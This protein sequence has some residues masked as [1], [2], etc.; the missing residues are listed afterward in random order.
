MIVILCLVNSIA[1]LYHT[2]QRSRSA[3][4][5]LLVAGLVYPGFAQA[6]CR[7]AM[8]K[9]FHSLCPFLIVIH[10]DLSTYDMLSVLAIRAPIVTFL[11]PFFH[12]TL[13][14][15][16]YWSY[17]VGE[18]LIEGC[19][20]RLSLFSPTTCFARQ[21]L[22]IDHFHSTDSCRHSPQ[23]IASL[24]RAVRQYV[25]SDLKLTSDPYL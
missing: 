19:A 5:D 17:I 16:P 14:K 21:R 12:Q 22:S 6:F 15:Y 24:P 11:S 1:A 4:G 23:S 13:P 18:G 2:A 20:A 8:A 10:V 25:Y 3:D 7:H 9:S